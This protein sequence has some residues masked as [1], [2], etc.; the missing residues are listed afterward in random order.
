MPSLALSC[1]FFVCCPL[2]AAI[3]LAR[4]LPQRAMRHS[5]GFPRHDRP[6]DSSGSDQRGPPA[7][8]DPETGWDGPDA[9]LGMPVV[10]GS[11]ASL[12][13]VAA[14]TK[15]ICCAFDRFQ[16]FP[17]WA[18]GPPLGWLRMSCPCD[19]ETFTDP[20]PQACWTGGHCFIWF[21]V[22]NYSKTSEYIRKS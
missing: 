4:L 14:W 3:L 12:V 10:T 7:T 1:I 22:H 8:L 19:H 6:T 18:E 17:I 5:L 11:A 13:M 20:K 15:T 21:Q 9:V 16:R 2:H